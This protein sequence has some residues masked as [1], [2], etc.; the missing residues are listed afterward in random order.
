MVLARLY[1]L[2]DGCLLREIDMEDSLPL[3]LVEEL[4]CVNTEL[5]IL[6][7]HQ[8]LMLSVCVHFD[9]FFTVKKLVY[10]GVDMIN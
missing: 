5:H 4:I 1:L 9:I 6:V 8:L 3:R 10:L 7:Y 2:Y